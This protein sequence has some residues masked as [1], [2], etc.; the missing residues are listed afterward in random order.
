[1]GLGDF[2]GVNLIQFLMQIGEISEGTNSY[3]MGYQN[4]VERSATGVSAL[5][6]AFKQRLLALVDSMNQA[7]QRVSKFWC[8]YAA[9]HFDKSLTVKIL[10][11]E[12]DKFVEVDVASLLGDFDIIFDAQSLKTATREV[13]R[14]QSIQLLT[15]AAT[16]GINPITGVPFVDVSKLWSMVIDSFE[17]QGSDFILSP[18]D[19]IKTQNAVQTYQQKQQQK[20][21][22]A[23]G[24]N[25]F[26][27]SP[28]GGFPGGPQGGLPAPGEIV[29]T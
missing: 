23:Q 29:D 2:S 12:A 3:G 4:K 1:M 17:L 26:P 6:T 13:R 28:Q 15:L 9:I 8:I 18:K 16:A 5:V 7:L 25:G 24:A 14:E 21:F 10:E 20:N 19:V 11:D 27:P 22:G